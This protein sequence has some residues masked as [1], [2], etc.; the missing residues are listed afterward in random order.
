MADMNAQAT[1]AQEAADNRAVFAALATGKVLDPEVA[2]RVHERGARMR[3]DLRRKFG[4]LDIGVPAIRELR[5][6]LPEP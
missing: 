3:D 5:G 4:I 2:R 6:D 1:D